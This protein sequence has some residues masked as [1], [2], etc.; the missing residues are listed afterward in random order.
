MKMVREVQ[1]D[2]G[3]SSPSDE[4]G[5]DSVFQIFPRFHADNRGHFVEVIRNSWGHWI[6][7]FSWMKQVNRSSSRSCVLRGCHA[8]RG[9]MCQGKLVEA[10]NR[11]I[12]DI[13]TDA[14][15]NSG[16]FGVTSVYRLDPE[17]HNQLWIPRGFLHAF[18]VPNS[19]TTEPEA[20]FQYYVDNAYDKTS[21]ICINPKSFLVPLMT[22]HRSMCKNMECSDFDA[23]HELFAREER[24]IISD[25]DLS[26]VDY[27]RFMTSVKLEYETSGR[28]WYR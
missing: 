5:C 27:N 24:L 28:L 3:F 6:R 17:V 8:Q 26:G 12:Y 21:E 4:C 13:I 7:D 20:I 19:E 1:F 18:A 9:A 23:L 16:S 25:K 15:P 2:D 22:C 14:R 11:T 10:V